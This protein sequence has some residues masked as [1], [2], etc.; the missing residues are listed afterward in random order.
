MA[1]YLFIGLMFA[2]F[3]HVAFT[4]NFIVKHLG[5]HSTFSII[6][7]ALLG[8][9]L[10]ICSCGVIPMALFLR[11]SNATKGAVMSFLISAPQ[12]GIDSIIATYGL[13][14]PVFAVFRPIVALLVGI[15]GGLIISISEKPKKQLNNI[16]NN[17]CK[18]CSKTD[19]HKHSI[20]EKLKAMLSY[21][22]VSFLDDISLQLIIGIIISGLIGFFIPHNFFSDHINNNFLTMLL[23]I[24]VCI[25]MY[26]CATASIP[27]ALSLIVKGISPGVA[28][29]FLVVGPATN[30]STIIL[31]TSAMGK[32]F[33]FI[34]LSVMIISAIIAGYFLNAFFN[35]FYTN[36]ITTLTHI[37][38]NY[39]MIMYVFTIIF[40]IAL[41]L[42]LLR[43]SYKKFYA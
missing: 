37:H 10:P 15:L 9:P 5:A 4:N 38:H 7:A 13:L 31:I 6:K 3:L 28:F 26:V 29:V 40:S 30:I 35:Y 12:T 43:K 36:S 22:Y 27:I 18:I 17:S 20:I 34:Y 16:L 19:Q 14:G 33:T 23:M 21:S 32:R 25:P 41:I 8:V 42:S 2:G 11:K 24:I 1:P 39:H